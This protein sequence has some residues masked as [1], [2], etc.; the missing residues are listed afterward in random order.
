VST[1]QN[2]YAFS[3][4]AIPTAATAL[5][6]LLFATR[7]LMRRVSRASISFFVLSLFVCIWQ[8]GFTGMFLA[9]TAEKASAWTKIAYIGIPF[10][11]PAVY[12]FAVE[13][14]RIAQRRRVALVVG[15]LLAVQ[16]SI[17]AIGTD[18]LVNGSYRF[19]WGFYPRFDTAA[20][21]SYLTFFFGFLIAAMFEFVHAH[22]KSRGVE[23]I[24]IRLLITAFGVA[25]I[26]C[27]DFAGDFGVD[28]YPFGYV[29]VITCILIIAH[30]V[31]RY[32]LIP[33]TPSL[34]ANEI[35]GTMADVLFVCDRDTRIQ[36]AN[37]SAQTVLGYAEGELTGRPLK[38]LLVRSDPEGIDTTMR[39]RSVR[40]AEYLFRTKGGGE[41]E[42]TLSISPVIHQGE[43]AGA[44]II[45]RDMRDRKR[46]ERE[47]RRAVTLLQST[48]DSTAD[49]ILVIGEGAKVL[50]HNQR[51]ADMWRIPEEMMKR[52][53]DRDLIGH[54]LEQLADPSDFVR[55]VDTL[56][57]QPEAESFDL[58]EFKDGRRFERYSIGR[59]F[60]G[61]PVRVWSF[62][63]VTARF[64]AE[65]ALRDSEV[66][67]RLLFEQNAAGVCVTNFSGNILDCNSTFARMLGYTRT[68]LVNRQMGDLYERRVERDELASMLRDSPILN[69]VE[70][71]LR[72]K[73]GGHVWV[74]QN[75]SLVGTDDDAF[76]HATLVDI[77][78]RKRAEE[79]IEYHAYHDVLTRLPN[80][81]LFTDRLA[82]S[83]TRSKRS[84]RSLAVLFIDLDHFKTVNDTLGHTAGD[85]LLLEMSQRLRDCIREDDTVAR[86]GGDEFTIILSD[87]RHPEDA[88]QVAQKILEAVEAPL[89]MGGM[90][91]ELSTSIGIALYPVDGHDVETLLRNADSAMYRAKE[92][93][94]NNY[95]LCTEEMKTRAMERLSLESRLRKAIQGDQLLLMYQPQVNLATGRVV[96]AE[97]LVRWNDPERGVIEPMAFIPIAEESRLIIPLG[98]WV[99]NAACREARQWRDRGLSNLRMAV[100]LSARQFQ[101]HD[102]VDMVQR[103]IKDAGIEPN[104]LELEITETTAMANAEL[105]IEILRA[106]CDVG[107]STAI[108]DFGSGYSSLAYLRR[109][110]INAVKIDR[111]FIMGVSKNEGDEAIVAAVIAI[112]R[113]LRLRVVA[114]GVETEEQFGFLQRRQC[115]EAQGFYFSPAMTAEMLSRTL[116]ERPVFGTHEPRMFL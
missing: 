104:A 94:R 2:V 28:I 90:T 105:T 75:L 55:T 33:I 16:F 73:D 37:N 57:Q 106:L 14:L 78:D 26:S 66:K 43:A 61:I 54:V 111:S 3:I 85:E 19:R 50:T 79:Q 49:G 107:V 81:R 80:R 77:S 23:R 101:Q 115:D 99:L 4:S 51:F 70:M 109:F 68:D 20:A 5:L 13:M 44:V 27:V 98:E 110:P 9:T 30:T 114:E 86:L 116:F 71:E 15:W 93:G 97:A 21:I 25:Y 1:G 10:V 62:R 113:S 48:L 74:L 53:D 60:E 108:D 84:G 100:N 31:R 58:L 24:R 96:G 7:V 88:M 64:A 18:Y 8:T 40:N 35:I 52:G 89:T 92:S 41:I 65:A 46:A 56:Y 38:E 83:I 82:L 32:D 12:H 67:Y 69:G 39:H 72:R 29:A 17:L 103:A 59:Y 87:L 63:D 22:P 6:A 102:L 36:F 45:G 91:I 47:T 112:A 76:I 11:A 95:Q 34:A 42:L